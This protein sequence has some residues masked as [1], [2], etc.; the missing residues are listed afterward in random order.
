MFVFDVV[1]FEEGGV[2]EVA[3]LCVRSLLSSAMAMVICI[4]MLNMSSICLFGQATVDVD[5]S[6]PRSDRQ[7]GAFGSSFMYFLVS[8]LVNQIIKSYNYQ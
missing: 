4:I 5:K 1:E 8:I 2:A 6:F 7:G 3:V